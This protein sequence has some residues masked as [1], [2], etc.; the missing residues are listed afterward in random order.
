MG[1]FQ[2]KNIKEVM[3]KGAGGPEGLGVKCVLRTV[4]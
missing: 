2:E 1:F 3:E 4:T